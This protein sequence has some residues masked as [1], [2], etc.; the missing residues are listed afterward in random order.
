[1]DS[2]MR[3]F[4]DPPGFCPSSFTSRRTRGLGLSGLTSTSGVLPMRS[5]TERCTATAS[6]G[7]LPAGDGGKDRHDVGV[8][9]LG[10]EL[11]EVADVV[12]VHVHVH[13]L[14]QT[15][16][17]VPELAAEPREAGDEVVEDLADRAPVGGNRRLAV[18]V[19]AH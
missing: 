14:V 2:A 3:S 11:V 6:P 5:R 7:V 16:V 12:V 18:G 1:M 13:E 17:V 8:G 9:H 4:T 10:V 15:A 19:L